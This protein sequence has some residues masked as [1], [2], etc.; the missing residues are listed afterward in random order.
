MVANNLISEIPDGITKWADTLILLD[1]QQ[2]RIDY[3]S[4]SLSKMKVLQSLNVSFNEFKVLPRWLAKLKQ[5]KEFGLDWFKYLCPPMDV[6]QKQNE[7]RQVIEK[8]F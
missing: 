8:L 2:N 7:G 3:L 1:V 4:E 6:V 5:L